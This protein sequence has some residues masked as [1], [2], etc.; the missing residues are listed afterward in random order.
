MAEKF[1]LSCYKFFMKN[2]AQEFSDNIKDRQ[3]RYAWER[4]A[5]NIEELGGL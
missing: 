2:S 1:S 4:L 5:Q 3:S